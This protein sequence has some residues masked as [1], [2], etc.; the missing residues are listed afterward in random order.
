MPTNWVVIGHGFV[1]PQ[2]QVGAPGMRADGVEAFQVPA[3][4][5][6]HFFVRDSQTL[7]TLHGFPIYKELMKPSPDYVTVKF[8]APY[9][10]KVEGGVIPDYT[11]H[12]DESWLDDNAKLASGIF[13]AGDTLHADPRCR[14]ITN[15]DTMRLKAFLT[16]GVVQPGDEVYWVS[17]RTW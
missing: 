13:I 5:A 17:C 7:L 2:E 10:Q 8:L 1:R 14:V 9:Y 4:V 3:G 12:G 16:G 6:I 15:K 11:L